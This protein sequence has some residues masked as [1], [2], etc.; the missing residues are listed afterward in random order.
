MR[1][2]SGAATIS[3]PK[4]GPR[5]TRRSMAAA[6]PTE[7]VSCSAKGAHPS[8]R[9]PAT[10]PFLVGLP[11]GI[12]N[13]LTQLRYPG[14]RAWTG[15]WIAGRKIVGS[16]RRSALG[17]RAGGLGRRLVD[18]VHPPRAPGAGGGQ[19]R[20]GDA[21]PDSGPLAERALARGAR[22]RLARRLEAL[23]WRYRGGPSPDRCTSRPPAGPPCGQQPPPFEASSSTNA[24]APGLPRHRLKGHYQ[25][26]AAASGVSGKW[27]RQQEPTGGCR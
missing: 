14:G 21:G 11:A 19:V 2:Q 23:W 8:A 6:P 22:G 12:C 27:T 7:P 13:K 16:T 15:R 25:N 17:A 1:V 24:R 10:D 5:T 9:G 26:L 20:L 18:A 3:C 4:A